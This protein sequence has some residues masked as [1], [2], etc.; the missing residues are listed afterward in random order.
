MLHYF[1]NADRHHPLFVGM[2]TDRRR[3]FVEELG[4][5][6]TVD[7]DGFECD[8]YD[9]GDV[10]PIYVICDIDG[11]HAGSF[12][13]LDITNGSILVDKFP[14]LDP[15]LRAEVERDGLRICEITRWVVTAG[16]RDTFK[17]LAWAS[18]RA[19]TMFDTDRHVALFDER[20]LR[21]CGL[22]GVRPATYRR[23]AEGITSAY[24]LHDP[25]AEHALG[26]EL[27]GVDHIV[28][29]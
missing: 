4:W 24:W 18:S 11:N 17:R 8:E 25:A 22:Y 3:Y 9:R 20:M 2:F 10:E 5:D 27:G 16:G 1:T 19:M 7:G 15:G 21:I 6:L 23:N 14:E 13:L 28:H 12:R 26:I 29:Q